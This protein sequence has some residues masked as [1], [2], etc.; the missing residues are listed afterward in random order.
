ML[1]AILILGQSTALNRVILRRRERLA[2]GVVVVLTRV[3]PVPFSRKL[4]SAIGLLTGDLRFE[5]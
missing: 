2:L 3:G 1:H 5:L 4:V